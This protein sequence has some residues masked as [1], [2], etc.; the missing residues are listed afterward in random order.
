MNI[1]DV[2]MC[3]ETV[4]G[5][6]VNPSS[7]DPENIDINDIAW[8]LSRIPRFAGHTITEVPYNVAQHSIYVSE[9]LE[10]LLS[11][12]HDH[13]GDIDVIRAANGVNAGGEKRRV[14]C[15]K[16]LLHDAHEAYL[17]DIP[18]PIKRIPELR[19]IFKI[20]EHKLDTAI[21]EK[22]KL[23][24]PTVDEEIVIK[25]CD[26]LAQAIESYQYMPSRGLNW[27]LPKPTLVRLQEFPA[28]L[29]PLKS[30][31]LFLERY[32]DLRMYS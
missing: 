26:K 18:S 16:A 8:S 19:P 21:W 23:K 22:M 5:K 17:G 15:T 31:E 20:I 6:L 11:N 10:Q 29:S 7:P 28:P 24:A 12:P 30:Y 27:N 3:I 9:L 2:S 1:I 25:Y 32:S 14:V 4:S 13:S